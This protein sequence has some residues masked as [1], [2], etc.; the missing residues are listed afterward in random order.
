MQSIVGFA[1]WAVFCRF[2]VASY[3]FRFCVVVCTSSLVSSSFDFVVEFVS[4]FGSPSVL[5]KSLCGLVP[6]P[7]PPGLPRSLRFLQDKK[8]RR[9]SVF[10][11]LVHLCHCV[12]LS[13]FQ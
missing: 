5:D 13:K 3:G 4:L 9:S 1:S 12:P 10:V 2:C 7:N 6:N 11:W 8:S